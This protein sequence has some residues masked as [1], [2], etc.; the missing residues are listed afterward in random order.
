MKEKTTLFGDHRCFDRL[1]QGRLQDLTG[2]VGFVNGEGG[3]R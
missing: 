1:F 3:I 2:G